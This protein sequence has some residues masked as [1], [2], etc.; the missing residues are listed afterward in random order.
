MAQR[1]VRFNVAYRKLREIQT[2]AIC[3]RSIQEIED[4]A[5]SQMRFLTCLLHERAGASPNYAKFHRQGIDAAIGTESFE[6]R[7]LQDSGFP[8]IVWKEFESRC[9]GG[10]SNK[11]H[12]FGP[13]AETLQLLHDRQIANWCKLMRSMSAE[14][15]WNMLTGFKGVGPKLSSFVLREFQ[16]F[17]GVWNR[18][19]RESWYCFMPL[20]RWVLRVLELLWCNEEWASE[21]PQDLK[22]YRC[23]AQ[24]ATEKFSDLDSAMNFNMGAWFLNAL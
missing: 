15:T 14:G 22:R 10:K 5:L 13:I 23:L 9:P 6:S 3:H 18:P 17:F 12:T 2:Q 19:P 16:A 24:A 20:D 21:P 8:A 11:S 1:Y 4:D 7:V